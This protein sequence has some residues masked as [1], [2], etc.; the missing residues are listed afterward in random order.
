[1]YCAVGGD[2]SETL[3]S[4]SPSSGQDQQPVKSVPVIG[5][6]KDATPYSSV[7]EDAHLTALKIRQEKEAEIRR[8]EEHW[9][10]QL[11]NLTNHVRITRSA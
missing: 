8:I 10:A 1:M 6:K 2:G 5:Q 9:R 4:S 11:L 7:M 3:K